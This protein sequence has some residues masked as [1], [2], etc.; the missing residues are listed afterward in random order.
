[1]NNDITKSTILR[2]IVLLRNYKCTNNGS[3]DKDEECLICMDSMKD[4]YVI[5]LQCNHTF[6]RECI[7]ENIFTY[8]RYAC[9]DTKCPKRKLVYE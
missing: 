5:T 2:E 7:M 6:H 8:E 9:P 4:Q 3:Y 1:M